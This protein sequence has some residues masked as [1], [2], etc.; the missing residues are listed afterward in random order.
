[1]CAILHDVAALNRNTPMCTSAQTVR[2]K[3]PICAE[4][5]GVG[6][7][8]CAGITDSCMPW[9]CVHVA[10]TAHS[11]CLC[12]VCSAFGVLP[13]SVAFIMY[14]DKLVSRSAGCLSC[15]GGSW[16]DAG[17]RVQAQVVMPTCRAVH[18]FSTVHVQ[19]DKFT[20]NFGCSAHSAS[21]G[22]CGS[23]QMQ[24]VHPSSSTVHLQADLHG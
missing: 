15:C 18:A 7:S 16:P 10:F 17:L 19:A 1:M 6:A 4:Q 14:Y 8:P 22:C 13:A 2:C 12:C 20:A 5:K 9:R 23:Y 11:V 3:V 21:A 24:S